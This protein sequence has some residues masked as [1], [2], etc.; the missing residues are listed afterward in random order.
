MITV[1]LTNM[2]TD[3]MLAVWIVPTVWKL[4]LEK[5]L[6]VLATILFGMRG[7]Y[8]KRETH[9]QDEWLTAAAF[10]LWLQRRFGE[11]SNSTRVKTQAVCQDH[12]PSWREQPTDHMQMPW[13]TTPS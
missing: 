6:R 4:A 11:S 13:S 3:V 9:V 7:V 2:I 1:I 8:V 10:P 5:E 12:T